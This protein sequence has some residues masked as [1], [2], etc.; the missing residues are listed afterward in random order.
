ME[1][2]LVGYDERE[3]FLAMFDS[4]VKDILPPGTTES[5]SEWFETLLKYNAT[6]GLLCW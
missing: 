1:D 6:T 3:A 5:G 2:K 4:V